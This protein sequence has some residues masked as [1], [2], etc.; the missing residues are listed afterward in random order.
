M[1]FERVRR[2]TPWGWLALVILGISG[3][4][5]VLP[6]P[7][8]VAV[9][10]GAL[11]ALALLRWHEL[12]LYIA[13]VAVPF[14]SW[15]PI[16]LGIGNLTAVDLAVALLM[17][18]WLARLIVVERGITIRFPPLSLPFAVFLF[19]ALVS[20]TGALS[21]QHAIKELTKW[22]EMFAVYLYVANNLDETRIERALAVIFL[23]GL[24]EA[25]IGIYQFFFRWGPKGFVLFGNYLR[26]FG[27]FEQPNP[28]AG[29]LALL[30]PVALGVVMS[31]LF[32][33]Q[34][35]AFARRNWNALLAALA[36]G[37][38]L[39]AAIMSWSR[40]A[41][42][43]IA[44]GLLVT[45]VVQSRRALVLTIIAAFA[46]TFIVLLNSINLVPDV[47]AARLSGIADYFGV[48]DVRG[49]KV[50]DANYA[51]VE[52]MAH[53]QAAWEMWLAHPAF[54]V[55]IGNYAVTY[56]AYALPR[57]DD[58]LGHAHNYYLNIA[59]ETGLVGLGAYVILWLAAFWQSWRAVR[60]ARGRWRGVAAGLLGMLVALSAH[61]LFDNLFVHGMAVQ[62]G[63]GLGMSAAINN[64]GQK[65]ES[66]EQRSDRFLFLVCCH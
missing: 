66:R 40:G 41:W 6:L 38:M 15:F 59:A 29:Y 32:T 14:G 24:A 7:S 2:A 30:I 19:A 39:A 54:G 42:L 63:I 33:V 62:V 60:A 50:D 1:M 26:A 48:F 36:L 34:G 57:W 28:F 37:A 52:R 53:W 43:G 4:L 3:A 23:A 13:I 16:P 46:L 21:L 44:A 10:G 5:I 65:S 56:P 8:A 64:R 47:I 25:A 61:N 22:F 55:G 9:M 17:G 31:S 12:A 58:P 35:F 49:V 18:L 45:V 20:L 51:V 27:T 11:L